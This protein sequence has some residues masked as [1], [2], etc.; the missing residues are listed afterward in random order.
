VSAAPNPP[1]FPGKTWDGD[2][3]I[4]HPGMTQRDYFAV[5]ASEEDV[6]SHWPMD[7]DWERQGTRV[8]ARYRFADAMLAERMKGL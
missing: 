2:S 5:H 4:F 3:A 1:A 8:E 6:L 7:H